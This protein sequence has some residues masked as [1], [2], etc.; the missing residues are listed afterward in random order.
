[1]LNALLR[2]FSLFFIFFLIIVLT[3]YLSIKDYGQ[4][5]V[6]SVTIIWIYQIFGLE[7]HNYTSR[8][9]A[10]L[11]FKKWSYIL[12][13]TTYLSLI[14]FCILFFLILFF[15][16][17]ISFYFSNIFLVFLIIIFEFFLVEIIRLYYV[18]GDTN[19][20][21]FF[22]FL[23]RSLLPIFIFVQVLFEVKLDLEIILFNWIITQI[24][25]L[26]LVILSLKKFKFNFKYSDFKIKKNFIFNGL[27]VALNYLVSL[28]FINTFFVID[29]YIIKYNFD[30]K[31]LAAYILFI[32]ISLVPEN[33]SH[34]LILS[35]HFKSL[36]KKSK[37]Y[38]QF[39]ELFIVVFLKVILL[40]L[41]FDFFFIILID[42]IINFTG[43][44]IFLKYINLSYYVLLIGNLFTIKKAL[45]YGLHALKKDK[46]ILFSNSILTLSFILLMFFNIDKINEKL[47]LFL[48]GI[49]LCLSIIVNLSSLIKLE[50]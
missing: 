36:I 13:N 21:N 28:V 26:I 24:I 20:F 9:L 37:K 48:I 12:I 25:T 45:D 17:Y 14:S 5:G 4:F 1:M 8:I 43:K 38:F 35:K 23:R 7:F 27:K 29:R 50:K 46:E 49:S 19:K 39:R 40:L 3:K 18:I 11:N 31:F 34:G 15:Y 6:I 16:E 42:D 2:L 22:E 10:N 41:I 33:L 32:S 30:L 47:F 44:Y